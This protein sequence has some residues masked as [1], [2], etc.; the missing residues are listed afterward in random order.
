MNEKYKFG[1]SY[2]LMKIKE[3]I[4]LNYKTLL[5]LLISCIILCHKNILYGIF[6][7]VFCTHLTY[8]VHISAHTEQCKYLNQIHEYHHNHTDN[9]AHYTQIF[10][11]L[12]TGISPIVLIYLFTQKMFLIESFEPYVIFMFSYFY[13]SIH[14]INYSIHH[15]NKIH[16]NHHSNW[17][18]NFGPDIL[19]VIYGTKEDYENL[20]NTDHYLGNLIISTLLFKLVQIIYPRLNNNWKNFFLKNTFYTYLS[21]S[22]FLLIFNMYL[23]VEKYGK[24]EM[25]DFDKKIKETIL[26]VKLF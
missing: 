5:G 2:H 18:I 8:I 10:L 16:E 17:N 12:T 21:M 14:N 1:N 26:K 19:D 24:N 4:F 9:F 20:E 15:V 6:L 25:K 11:E 13:S 22:S 23:L 7:Y 3:S